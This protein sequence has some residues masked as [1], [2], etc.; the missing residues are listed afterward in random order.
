MA[1]CAMFFFNPSK[2]TDGVAPDGVAKMV[3]LQSD[4]RVRQAERKLN[5]GSRTTRNHVL[6]GSSS[7][8]TRNHV[9]FGACCTAAPAFSVC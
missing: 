3:P 5:G 4:V 9:A 1:N 8:T 7:R 2:D 6:N